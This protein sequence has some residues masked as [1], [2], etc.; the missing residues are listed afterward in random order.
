MRK[1][2][3]TPPCHWVAHE[4]Q[5]RNSTNGCP[6]R[7]GRRLHRSRARGPP[8]QDAAEQFNGDLYEEAHRQLL[9]PQKYSPEEIA[10]REE[11][12]EQTVADLRA[13]LHEN[14]YLSPTQFAEK[15]ALQYA[16]ATALAAANSEGAAKTARVVNEPSLHHRPGSAPWLAFVVGLVLIGIAAMVAVFAG[17][18]LF[19]GMPW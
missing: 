6:V 12:L 2:S 4:E 7:R 11:L 18:T 10:R 15:A 9:D 19:G 13:P 5:G 1:V 14:C 16:A 3:S 17:R 8:E